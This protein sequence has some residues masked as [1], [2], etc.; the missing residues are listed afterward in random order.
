MSECEYIS[1]CPFFNDNMANISDEIEEMKAQ[2]CRSNN[3]NCA[4]YMVVNALGKEMMP[5]ELYPHE[6]IKAYE[7]IAERG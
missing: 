5:P 2:Y 1:G 7:L 4:R 6:K 3:L